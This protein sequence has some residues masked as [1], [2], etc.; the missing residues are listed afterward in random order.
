MA[1]KGC[2]EVSKLKITFYSSLDV[3]GKTKLVSEGMEK[4]LK[5][6]ASNTS[7]KISHELNYLISPDVEITVEFSNSIS[8]NTVNNILSHIIGE[9]LSQLIYKPSDGVMQISVY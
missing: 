5:K 8:L 6:Y 4:Y 9:K 1:R 3:G 2:F 7:C